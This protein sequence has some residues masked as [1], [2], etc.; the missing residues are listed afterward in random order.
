MHGHKKTF[1][2]NAKDIA[3]MLGNEKMLPNLPG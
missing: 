1:F 3:K 2:G